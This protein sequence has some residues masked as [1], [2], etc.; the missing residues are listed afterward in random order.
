MFIDYKRR[1]I[2]V[3]FSNLNQE[4]ILS[5]Y[6]A[7]IAGELIPF[8]HLHNSISSAVKYAQTHIKKME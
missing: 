4:H 3:L 6:Q 5:L 2:A 8:E 1:N 7:D